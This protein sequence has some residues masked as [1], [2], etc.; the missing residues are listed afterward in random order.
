MCI[1]QRQ[2]AGKQVCQH[3]ANF[4]CAQLDVQHARKAYSVGTSRSS[5]SSSSANGCI[6]TPKN[7]PL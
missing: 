1:V 6:L 2:E 3:P 4:G 5:T 7:R